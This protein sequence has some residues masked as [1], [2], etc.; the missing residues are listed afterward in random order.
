MDKREMEQILAQAIKKNQNALQSSP[1]KDRAETV[2]SMRSA[3]PAA[4]IA[5]S[6]APPVTVTKIPAPSLSPKRNLKTDFARSS[7]AFKEY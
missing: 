7:V 1:V 3:S 5:S 4:R 2:V 6:P